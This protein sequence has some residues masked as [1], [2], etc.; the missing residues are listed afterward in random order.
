MKIF[1]VDAVLLKVPSK[2]WPLFPDWLLL[3]DYSMR[4]SVWWKVRA[5]SSN[6]WNKEELLVGLLEVFGSEY[7][8]LKAWIKVC[9]C[10]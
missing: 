4:L 3:K 10:S 7:E 2:A 6:Q 5:F 9:G 1:F 8:F